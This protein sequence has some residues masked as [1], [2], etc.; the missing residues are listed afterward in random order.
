MNHSDIL[1]LDPGAMFRKVDLHVHTP[2]S[3]DM[4]SQWGDATPADVIEHAL[5]KDLDIIAITDHNTAAWC[6]RVRE[7]ASS[8][9]LRVL[10]GVEISTSEGHVLAVFDADKPSYEIEAL[11]TSIG[12]RQREFGNL[13]AMAKLNITEVAAKVV[14]EGG[15]AIAAHVESEKGFHRLMRGAGV[16]RQRIAECADLHAFEIVHVETRNAFPSGAVQGYARKVACVQGSDCW[17][18]AADQHHLDAIGHR[19]CYLS[20]G[21]RSIVGLRQA[22]VDPDVRVRLSC[23]PL[24]AQTSVIEGVSVTGGFLNDQS[25]RFSDTVTCLIGGTGSGKSLTLELIRFALGQQVPAGVLP[26]VAKSINDLLNFAVKEGDTVALMVRRGDDRYLIQRTWLAVDAPPPQLSRVLSTGALAEVDG[27]VQVSTF[28]PIKAFSQSEI[29]EYSREPLARLSLV[30]DLIEIGDDRETI[31]RTKS[32]LRSNARELMELQRQ[33]RRMEVSLESLPG[34]TEQIQRLEELLDHPHVKA[35]DLW[36]REQV[37]LD[38]AAEVLDDLYD[39]MEVGIRTDVALLPDT[40]EESPSNPDLLGQVAD[41]QDTLTKL[42]DTGKEQLRQGVRALRE[43]LT[44]VRAVWDARFRESDREYK[45]LLAQLDKDGVGLV[46]LHEKLQGLRGR[47]LRLTATEGEI[48]SNIDPRLS[49]LQERGEEL[50]TMLQEARS[51]ITAKRRGKAT[52]LTNRLNRQVV[53]DMNPGKDNRAFERAL[54]D[55]RSGARHQEIQAM[56]RELHPVPLVKSLLSGD[57]KTPASLAGVAES[58]VRRLGESVIQADRLDE[59]YELQL[60][61]LE[62]LTDIRLE[63]ETGTYKNIEHLA[64]GQKCT[65]VL[66]IAL[67]EGEFPLIVD[68]PEDALHAPWIEDY[69]VSSLRGHARATRQCIFATRSANVLVSADAAQVIAMRGDA[70]RGSVERTGALDSFATRD[71]V[72]YHVEGGEEAFRRRWK[73]YSY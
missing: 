69:V 61:D 29:V 13:N 15:V 71:L 45:R 70:Y 49:Q 28:F 24:P 3:P 33:R 12:I 46:A 26:A 66:M 8:T 19:Y 22:L 63:V 55:L 38:R 51:E 11:L 58:T 72:V 30:D 59:L 18:E 16:R 64:H 14:E 52:E 17:A 73:K 31:E 53:I 2:A 6:D 42:L 48:E 68:Q 41:L 1:K 4:H 37:L 40:V 10:P 21:E 57:F 44:G 25:F 60:V 7:A 47:E 9:K 54:L 43:Q 27:R 35:R 34:I 36:Y 65:V 50:L 67:A 62:D 39:S 32:A 23:D 20:M 56:A 5:S